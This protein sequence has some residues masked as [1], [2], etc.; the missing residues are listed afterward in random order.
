M[1]KDNLT[2]AQGWTIGY[3]YENQNRDIFQK[4]LEREFSIRKS[5]ASTTLKSMEKNG[6]ITRESVPYDTRLKKIVLTE[7][8]KKFHTKVIEKV[9]LMEQKLVQGIPE[10][11]IEVF[12][13]VMEKMKQNIES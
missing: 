6:M 4:D 3:L 5:T 12:F 9:D 11:E 8:A 10:E 2:P 1:D 7:K 13:R